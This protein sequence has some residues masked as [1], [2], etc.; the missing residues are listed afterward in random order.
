MNINTVLPLIVFAVLA[1]VVLFQLYSVLGRRMGRQPEEKAPAALSPGPSTPSTAAEAAASL[2]ALSGLPALKAKDSAFDL[3]TFLDGA[4]GAYEMIV[5]AFAEGDRPTLHR[6]LA[7]DVL[8]GFEVVIA[9][10][11]AEGR[12]EQVEFQRPPRTDLERAEVTGDVA[13]LSVRFLAELRSRIKSPQGE[14][15]DDRRTAEVWTFER[16]LK[17]KDPN[18]ILVRVDPAEA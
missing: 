18:W 6:L 8:G 13:R 14:A 10:R 2:V 5:R 17:S 1:A 15:V 4:K 7:A 16:N 11:E 12:T 3:T 9:A